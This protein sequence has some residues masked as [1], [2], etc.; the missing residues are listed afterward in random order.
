[1]C[2]CWLLASV[3]DACVV[4]TETMHRHPA[5]KQAANTRA[6]ISEEKIEKSID[7]FLIALDAISPFVIMFV[8][9]GQEVSYG[10]RLLIG[11]LPFSAILSGYAVKKLK[12]KVV[13]YVLLLN[14]YLGYLFFYS[15][16]VLTL[17]EGINLC[18][19]NSK[20][21]AENYYLNLYR[22]LINIQEIF[23]ALTK[24]IYFATFLRQTPTDLLSTFFTKLS[25]S[26]EQ[27]DKTIQLQS[28]YLD[29]SSSYV[30]TY[31]ATVLLFS[32]LFFYFF[33]N[34]ISR[35]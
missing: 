1:M 20:F 17:R 24:N 19:I 4:C 14:T 11:I 9:G 30:N 26:S 32:F 29:F 31:V 13:I 2:F 12:N 6:S 35:N 7:K 27:I 16:K 22:A 23:S 3:L 33:K 28:R 21:T 8:W 25:I 5:Q 18:G 10:Q 15:S 34:P